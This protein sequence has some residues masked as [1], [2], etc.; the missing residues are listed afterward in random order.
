MNITNE[1]IRDAIKKLDSEY[2]R[3]QENA[4]AICNKLKDLEY[5]S[6]E[7]NAYFRIINRLSDRREVNRYE[8]EKLKWFITHTVSTN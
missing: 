3:M 8:C 7:Y 2:E 5:D 1:Q 4:K 6:D